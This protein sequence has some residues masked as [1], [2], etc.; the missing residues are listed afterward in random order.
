M[1]GLTKHFFLL[2][3][4]PNRNLSERDFGMYS[5]HAK[6]DLG[7]ASTEIELYQVAALTKDAGSGHGDTVKNAAGVTGVHAASDGVSVH[8]RSRRVS[9]IAFLFFSSISLSYLLSSSTYHSR[10]VVASAFLF[11]FATSW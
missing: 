9:A 3:F 5:C 11:P 7:S 1:L 2:S 8:S 6:N 4:P 10:S